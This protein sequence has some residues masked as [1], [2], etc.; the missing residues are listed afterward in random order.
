MG[1]ALYI[2]AQFGHS[3]GVRLDN[4]C[5][6][7]SFTD[8][9]ISAALESLGLKYEE[10]PD[11]AE[12]IAEMLADNKIIGLFQGRME[13]GPRALG[14]R[15][16]LADP[17]STKTRDRV[18]KI[19]KREQWRPLSPALLAEAAD[20]VLINAKYSPFMLCFFSI[21]DDHKSAL[22]G[23]THVDGTCRPQMVDRKIDGEFWQIINQW[24]A[25]SGI[26]AIL[27]TSFN[28]RDEPIICTPLDAMRTFFSSELDAIVIGSF[29][30]RKEKP[31]A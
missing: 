30:L 6:G 29:L 31:K 17:T 21:R 8:G 27:N 19:K 14:H 23:V 1:A 5:W 9:Q 25:T 2:S 26:P 12:T 18:N 15:S 13:V 16:I 20:N 22:P 7:P 10:L 24:K 3:V 28:L 4:A 11:V